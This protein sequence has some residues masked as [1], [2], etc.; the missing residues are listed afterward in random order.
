MLLR[1]RRYRA[2][3]RRA[4]RRLKFSPDEGRIILWQET[5]GIGVDHHRLPLSSALLARL[6]AALLEYEQA[7]DGWSDTDQDAFEHRLHGL[8]GDVQR[9]LGE[10]GYV[11][12]GDS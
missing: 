9:E 12:V 8:L 6:D 10:H 2:S 7:D 11:V 3:V 5:D 1:R 4:S